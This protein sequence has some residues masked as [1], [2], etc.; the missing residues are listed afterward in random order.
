MSD[1]TF[2]RRDFI[3]GAGALAMAA[4]LPV[5]LAAAQPAVGNATPRAKVQHPCRY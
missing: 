5:A 3:V 1:T 2:D 4:S